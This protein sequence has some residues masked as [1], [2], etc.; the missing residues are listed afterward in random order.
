[1]KNI[2]ILIICA[3]TLLVSISSCKK[4]DDVQLTTAQKLPY[5]WTFVNEIVLGTSTGT[6]YNDTTKGVAGEYYDFML[7]N[8]LEI[9]RNSTLSNYTYRLLGNDKLIFSN[10]FARPDTLLIRTLTSTDLQ[11]YSELNSAGTNIQTTINLR[12]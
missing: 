3:T 4:T 8:N 7:N 12:R 11:L 5:K 10:S 6:T 9:K 2:L 1:M